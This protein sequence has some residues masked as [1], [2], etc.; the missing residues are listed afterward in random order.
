MTM[1]PEAMPESRNRVLPLIADSGNRQ[2]LE[3][4]IDDHPA[5]ESVAVSGDIEDADFDVCIVDKGAFQ[6]HLDAL[7]AKKTAAAPV[8]LPYLLLLPESGAEI[9]ESDAGQLADSVV[10]ETIDEIVSLPIQQAE[11][12]WRLE[13]LFRL[14]NQ[15]LTL[16]ERERELERQIDLFEKAQ[17]IAN[18]GAWEYDLDAE[19]GWW[20]DEARCIH[21]LQDDTT[22][23]PE[24]SL[25]HFHP[26]DR[27]V[28]E[29]AFE[30]AVEEG[31][32]Y[33]VEVRLI[34][35][36]DNLRWVRTRG[37][38]QYEDGEL[39]RVRGTIQDITE[40]KERELDLQRI[41]QAV[42]SAGHAILITDPDGRIEYVNSG[43]EEITGFTQAEVVGET[44][45]VLNSG[46]MPEGYFE[47]FWNTIR[48]GEV[49]A[50]EIV[51]RRKNGETYTAMQTVAPVIDDDEIHAFVAV[52]DDITERKEREE[53]LK[54]RTQAIDEAPVG[55]TI[56]DPEREDNPMIYVNDAFVDLTGYPRA[57]AVGEN[58]R[59]LQG[60]STDPDQVAEIREAIDAEEPI[61]I[62]L[63]N[64]RKDGTEFWNQLEITPVY[65]DDEVTHFLGVQE[66]VT[67]R[68]ERQQKLEEAV[69][70]LRQTRDIAKVSGWLY[71]VDE[72]RTVWDEK[73]FEL[74]DIDQTFDPNSDRLESLLTPK[75][76]AKVEQVMEEAVVEQRPFDIE[77]AIGDDEE[78]QY[79][80][81]VIGEP[82]VEEGEVV[83]V[84]GVVRDITSRKRRERN[85]ERYERIVETTG[86]A[87]YALNEDLEVTFLNGA[88][89][90][91]HL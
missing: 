17:D 64:Y 83:T 15:S 69:T 77:V 1:P 20:T 70:E 16:R 67:E 86:E 21:A 37:E 3:Q 45:H 24:L 91:R 58:C 52:Q 32:P 41:K 65:D 43:F 42:E 81:Q 47:D 30:T 60:E 80:A 74:F 19:E 62:E 13:A 66:D 26:A 34:D 11:L 78:H 36:E 88:G 75:S 55:I 8:L 2:L 53:T 7:R 12:D 38:P 68:K 18:V 54:R 85:L 59:F 90:E 9:L 5:Y 31:E 39:A 28:V 23:S 10:T 72:Q 33:D 22:P 84:R 61:S 82:T 79:W 46:A 6:E 56:T 44:P 51:N 73:L 4:W 48:S 49:W 76:M 57:E 50:E 71:D 35:A 40:R 87:I 29:A 27:S 89:E 25:Q 63:K 14:R